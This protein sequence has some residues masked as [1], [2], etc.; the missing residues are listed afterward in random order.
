MKSANSAKKIHKTKSGSNA[1]D[2]QIKST[3]L[4][5]SIKRTETERVEEQQRMLD[6]ITRNPVRRRRRR[7]VKKELT[8][9][10]RARKIKKKEDTKKRK[11]S[12][13]TEKVKKNRKEKE[14]L[15]AKSKRAATAK[16]RK[17]KAAVK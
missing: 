1:V 15:V 12:T 10:K 17:N 2:Y 14:N 13:K 4:A 16:V 9:P 7:V 8:K 3:R 5:D 6:L 11:V